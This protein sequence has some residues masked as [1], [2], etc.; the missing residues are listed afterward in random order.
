M[1]WR[2]YVRFINIVIVCMKTTLIIVDRLLEVFSNVFMELRVCLCLKK[3]GMISR[4]ITVKIL[5]D[6][7]V[8]F[9]RFQANTTDTIWS[10][11]RN[12]SGHGIDNADNCI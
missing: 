12:Y 6:L 5:V 9:G 8:R 4:I 10:S 1:Q 2:K 3:L 7:Q 11:Y